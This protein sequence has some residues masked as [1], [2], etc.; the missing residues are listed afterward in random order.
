MNDER[1]MVNGVQ[2]R[3][4][5]SIRVDIITLLEFWGMWSPIIDILVGRQAIGVSTS[6]PSL[7]LF[8]HLR[9]IYKPIVGGQFPMASYYGDRARDVPSWDSFE[10]GEDDEA[11]DISE[12]RRSPCWIPDN[13]S[14][15]PHG[16]RDSRWEGKLRDPQVCLFLVSAGPSTS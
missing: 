15:L 11:V 14:R 12:V 10:T 3:R 5:D 6:P 1:W 7:Y 8:C 9:L 4:L 2:A 16:E 13:Q